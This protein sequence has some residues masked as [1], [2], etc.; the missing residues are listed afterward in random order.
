MPWQGHALADAGSCARRIAVRRCTRHT[1][2]KPAARFNSCQPMHAPFPTCRYGMVRW[3]RH[4]RHLPHRL[5][6]H[7][8]LLQPDSVVHHHGKRV[9]LRVWQSGQCGSRRLSC[10]VANAPLACPL[11]G[12]PT[13]VAP[14]CLLPLLPAH[15][16][17][18]CCPCPSLPASPNEMASMLCHTYRSS[19]WPT[20]LLPHPAPHPLQIRTQPLDASPCPVPEPVPTPAPVQRSQPGVDLLNFTPA[21]YLIVIFIVGVVWG[22]GSTFGSRF[23]IAF[24]RARQ[25]AAA[26]ARRHA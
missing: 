1:Q 10:A 18:C 26:G 22:M 9:R 13:G 2:P 3:V 6:L 16:G 23:A 21:G 17:C 15:L 5:L 25:R 24:C 12:M 7:T 11:G 19:A 20:P 8:Q 14:K 4:V